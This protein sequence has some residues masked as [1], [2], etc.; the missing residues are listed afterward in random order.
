[1]QK[2]KKILFLCQGAVIAAIY[3][4][5]TLLSHIFG[6]GSGAVQLRISEALCVLPAF[7]PA[8]IPGLYVGCLLSA[9]LTGAV[10]LDVL[11]GPV[12][13]LIGAL[14]A[15]IICRGNV[16]GKKYI[17][18]LPTLLSNTLLI[19]PVLAYGYGIQTA[20]PL[21]YLTVG[22][23]ELLSAYVLG[24]FFYSALDKRRNQIFF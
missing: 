14:G 13:T 2:N 23:S 4:A 17:V 24:V 21:L 5:L 16:R 18:A 11:I 10:W 12:A 20:L 1:M 8:A 15:Y 6:L 9:L 19:P 3:T 22:V 7:A